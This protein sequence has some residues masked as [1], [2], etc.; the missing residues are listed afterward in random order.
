MYEVSTSILSRKRKE[1]EIILALEKARTDYIHID[2]M[3]GEFVE[4]IHI[5]KC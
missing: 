1:A 3:D 5:K 4:K 2:V